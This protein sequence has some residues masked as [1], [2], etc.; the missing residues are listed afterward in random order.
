MN[1]M[2]LSYLLLPQPQQVVETAALVL[3]HDR[4]EQVQILGGGGCSSCVG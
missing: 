2:K 1:L 3:P 4:S